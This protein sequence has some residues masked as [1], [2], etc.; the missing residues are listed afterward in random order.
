MKQHSKISILDIAEM[1]MMVA[2]LEAG[3]FTLQAIPNVEV[4]T[5]LFIVFTASFGLKTIL[6]SFA[7]T[8]LETIWWG[9]NTWNVMYLYIWPLLIV[10][11]YLTRKHAS[12]WFYSI[13]SCI[14]GLFFGALCSIPYFFIGGPHMMFTWWIAG[15]P[16][17]ILHGISNFAVCLVLYK[18][19]MYAC[20][21][22]RK[23]T[24]EQTR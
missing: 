4:V 13:S 24:R 19:L 18:P 15:I 16:Y 14:F 6:V 17:D 3:K 21:H 7:F 12:V 2:L 10:Y 23:L 5:L 9:I 8:G 1:G 20:G 22:I 11:V